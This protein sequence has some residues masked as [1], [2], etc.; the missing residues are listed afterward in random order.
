[1]STLRDLKRF[2]RACAKRGSLEE[3]TK[4]FEE[5]ARKA[6]L[7]IDMDLLTQVL[8]EENRTHDEAV[9]ELDEKLREEKRAHDEAVKELE[10]KIADLQTQIKSASNAERIPTETPSDPA[11]EAAEPLEEIPL[12]D[13]Q[14][15]VDAFED[16]RALVREPKPT[17]SE[18]LPEEP[19]KKKR[20]GLF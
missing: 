3:K 13:E 10:E 19:K 8:Q 20:R 7:A 15:N 6:K 16:L 1:M 2:Q 9:K 12:V 5:N 14:V 17:E 11:Q 4:V 18:V